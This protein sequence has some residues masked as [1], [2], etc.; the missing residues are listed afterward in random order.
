[1]TPNSADHISLDH[2]I[3]PRLN[4]TQRQELETANLLGYV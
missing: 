4:D 1:M 3:L 2:L